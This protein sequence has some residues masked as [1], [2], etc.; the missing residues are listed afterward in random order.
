MSLW[1]KALSYDIQ[2]VQVDIQQTVIS[3]TTKSGPDK[4]EERSWTA[5]EQ[6]VWTH[7]IA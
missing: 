7:C 5:T 1:E 2:N 3:M 6:Y 4:S